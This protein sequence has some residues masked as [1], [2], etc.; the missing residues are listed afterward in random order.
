MLKVNQQ[1]GGGAQVNGGQKEEVQRIV[2]G[3]NPVKTLELLEEPLD[4]MPLLNI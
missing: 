4:R 1:N 2:S 3:G